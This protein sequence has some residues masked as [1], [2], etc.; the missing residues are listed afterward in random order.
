MS[1]NLLAQSFVPVISLNSK[2]SEKNLILSFSALSVM[3]VK[4]K[5]RLA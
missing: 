1:N 3:I 5:L 4:L 2:G